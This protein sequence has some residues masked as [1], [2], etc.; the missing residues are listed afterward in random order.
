[1]YNKMKLDAELVARCKNPWRKFL[2]VSRFHN[3]DEDTLLFM[4]D[5]AL[6]EHNNMV[7][8]STGEWERYQRRR[9][10][11]ISKAVANRLR[12]GDQ[13]RQAW[14]LKMDSAGWVETDTLLTV[15]R[16]DSRCYDAEFE[17]LCILATTGPKGRIQLGLFV[18]GEPGDQTI[19]SSFIRFSQG[20]SIPF[21]REDRVAK[22]LRTVDELKD[23]VRD[24]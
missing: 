12:H 1:M 15:I 8:M 4:S 19:N 17:D 13:R 7:M 21:A 23:C 22:V 5:K 2:I 24:L 10:F 18:G 11:N 6:A 3:N 16:Q 14:V 9:Y 20:S